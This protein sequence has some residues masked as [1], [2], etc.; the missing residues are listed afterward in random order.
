[1]HKT[2]IALF[3]GTEKKPTTLKDDDVMIVTERHGTVG[4][5]RN[6]SP[7]REQGGDDKFI[8]SGASITQA[9]SFF[10]IT[11]ELVSNRQG[12]RLYRLSIRNMETPS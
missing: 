4:F 9:L 1:M 6:G 2:R 7:L 12:V 3:M 8:A 5:I 10:G 11:A